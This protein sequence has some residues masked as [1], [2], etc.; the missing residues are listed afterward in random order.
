MA[1]IGSPFPLTLARRPDLDQQPLTFT[2]IGLPDDATLTPSNIYPGQASINWVPTAADA[3][4]YGVTFVVTN[5]GNGNPS[6]VASAQQTIHLGSAA[7]PTRQ[8]VLH[9]PGDADRCRNAEIA[10]SEFS[11]PPTRTA[12]R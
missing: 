4:V 2:A 12:T 9:N 8:P 1:V 3:G 11:Q 5:T 10:D 6:L 7:P